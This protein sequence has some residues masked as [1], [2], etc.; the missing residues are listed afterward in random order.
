M[1]LISNDDP[2]MMIKAITM[3]T[4]TRDQNDEGEDFAIARQDFV[5]CLMLKSKYGRW[6]HLVPYGM[7]GD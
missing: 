7:S 3:K 4:I 6:C 5:L 2:V 1:V